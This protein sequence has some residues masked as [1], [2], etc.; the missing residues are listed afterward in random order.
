MK[1]NKRIEFYFSMYLLFLELSYKNKKNF[2]LFYF[3][4][5]KMDDY[6]DESLID[7][8]FDDDDDDQDD[9]DSDN[10][11]FDQEFIDDNELIQEQEQ[12]ISSSTIKSNNDDNKDHVN[13]VSVAHKSHI[14]KS[15]GNRKSNYH[16]NRDRKILRTPKCARYAFIL[17]IKVFSINV[18]NNIILK[19]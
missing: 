3:R 16:S 4:K 18:L 5:N 8:M 14:K 6:D 13:N 15:F 12:E 7:V 17:F 19:M 10:D 9:D 1:T 2:V 11:D